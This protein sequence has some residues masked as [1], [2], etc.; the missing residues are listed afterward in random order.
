MIDRDGLFLSY[1]ESLNKYTSYPDPAY[2]FY[3]YSFAL[4]PEEY[5][6]TGQVNM[7]RISHKKIDIELD[8][9]SSTNRIDVDIYAVNYNILHIESGLAGLKF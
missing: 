5:Y 7:S 4:K 6:P 9:T 3:M 2:I 1:Q 8:E